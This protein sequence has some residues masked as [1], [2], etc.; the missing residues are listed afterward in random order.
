MYATLAPSY[1][2]AGV[3]G[4]DVAY[5]ARRSPSSR[6]WYTSSPG[7]LD[8]Q[9]GTL[10]ALGG[11]IPYVV[12]AACVTPDAL[13]LLAEAGAPVNAILHTYR[14]EEEYLGLLRRL[15]AEG[16]RLATQRPHP[17]AEVAPA[18]LV[19]DR[20]LLEDINDK[21][22]I[23]E[24]VPE[25]WLA[26]R[27]VYPIAE[28][29]AAEALLA[30][31]EPVVLKVASAFPTG[32]GNGV[33]I[34]RTPAD[35]ERA[36]TACASERGVVVEEYLRIARSVCVHTVVFGDGSC[37]IAGVAE[38]ICR[39]GKWVGN[40][41]DQA[42][43]AV[44]GELRD[45]V[46]RVTA[47]ASARGY[48]GLA[49]VDVAICRDGSLRMLDLNFRVNASTGGVWLRSAIERA[50]GVATMRRG[51]WTGGSGITAMLRV[52]K[53]A[54]RRGSMIPLGIY[55]PGAGEGGG[56]PRVSGLL[57]SSSREE[58]EEEAR[59]LA[60]EGLGQA[61]STTLPPGG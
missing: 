40:W 12:S 31:G 24:Y 13:A 54:V 26:P 34:C 17:D 28:L 55:D 14:S 36:R 43:D 37:S 35:V 59:R 23:G 51:T 39:H 2:L 41:F 46:S 56:L 58:V 8:S 20:S 38:E 11:G 53:A 6:G 18:S 4:P 10:L 57:L 52:V 49:G 3:F 15:A 22:R 16:L 1:T 48:R 5:V 33:W 25:E 47:A 60:V 9:T 45:A 50:R 44:P 21:G 61:P 7:H 42:G 32:G 30:S 29:P 19:V 27:V